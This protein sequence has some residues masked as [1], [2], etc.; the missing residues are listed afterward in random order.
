MGALSVG[1]WRSKGEL[2]FYIRSRLASQIRKVIFEQKP[3]GMWVARGTACAKAI[4][5]E[6]PRCA[7]LGITRRFRWRSHKSSGAGSGRRGQQLM[8]G[9]RDHRQHFALDLLVVRLE[10]EATEVFE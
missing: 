3:E 10:W 2:L 8:Q 6:G 9:P 5:Q 4:G 7:I 1:G